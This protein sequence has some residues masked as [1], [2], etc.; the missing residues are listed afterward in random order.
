MRI[1]LVADVPDQLVVLV[2]L[3]LGEQSE[4]Q[5]DDPEAGAE[6]ATGAD[7]GIDDEGTDLGRQRAQAV[8]VHVLDVFR[9]AE[10]IEERIFEIGFCAHRSAHPT[11]SK[12]PDKGH[13][14][15]RRGKVVQ[16]L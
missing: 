11:R 14:W 4:G 12:R 16:D 3:V 9:G 8:V 1:A 2:E 6:V 7:D 10:C 5:L 13:A 15:R